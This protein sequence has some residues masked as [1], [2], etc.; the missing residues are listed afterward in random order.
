MIT[1]RAL[2]LR[3]CPVSFPP[4]EV[5]QQGL[6][7]I[8]QFLRRTAVA[9]WPLS[10]H[11]AHMGLYTSQINASISLPVCMYVCVCLHMFMYI[12][13][14]VCLSVCMCVCVIPHHLWL[15]IKSMAC[16]KNSFLP[17]F[18]FSS[19]TSVPLE[20]TRVAQLAHGT[21]QPCNIFSWMKMMDNLW[22]C[23]A[24]VSGAGRAKYTPK[25]CYRE[26]I[27]KSVW[28]KNC[29]FVQKCVMLLYCKCNWFTAFCISISGF[30]VIF[31]YVIL[32][33]CLL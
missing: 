23:P 6:T 1:L 11:S 12:N 30:H 25:L 27:L 18:C 4:Q 31:L 20:T 22:H 15:C 3:N 5:L 2:S 26:N 16:F 10:V 13:V 29:L 32:F 14:C 21:V 7:H 9:Q 17:W 8:L 24:S 19:V 33:T 28:F